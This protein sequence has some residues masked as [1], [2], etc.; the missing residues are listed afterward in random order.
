MKCKNGHDL[1][2]MPSN[3]TWWHQKNGPGW[4]DCT[5]HVDCP[6]TD[7]AEWGVGDASCASG[8]RMFRQCRTCHTP[9][10]SYPLPVLH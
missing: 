6:H 9:L 3:G 4:E 8:T 1:T 10:G 7:V 5:A 2:Y